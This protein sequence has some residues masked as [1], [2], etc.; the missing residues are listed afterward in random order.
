MDT[1]FSILK[2]D[3]LAILELEHA[4][5]KAH[6]YLPGE[7]DRMEALEESIPS[8]KDTSNVR[9]LIGE[10][11]GWHDSAYSAVKCRL[12]EL[13]CLLKERCDKAVL[14]DMCVFIDEFPWSRIWLLPKLV[15]VNT[16]PQAELHCRMKMDKHASFV[17]RW[18]VDQYSGC[19]F[20]KMGAHVNQWVTKH[21]QATME[22]G[23]VVKRHELYYEPL[24][25]F[26]DYLS[27]L[28]M[29]NFG[30]E[31]DVYALFDRVKS[32]VVESDEINLSTIRKIPWQHWVDK[33]LVEDE[34]FVLMENNYR[35]SYYLLRKWPEKELQS[36]I[37][38]RAG[39]I[40]LPEELF[41]LQDLIYYER[42][43]E[44]PNGEIII[45]ENPF[46][47]PVSLTLNLS[48]H[49]FLPHGLC[50]RWKNG[51]IVDAYRAIPYNR[52]LS[53]AENVRSIQESYV[54]GVSALSG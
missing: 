18:V 10:L 20:A 25:S 41:D 5:A 6:L 30:T 36:Y 15:L 38:R 19:A 2:K 33:I 13:M 47:N 28:E 34:R 37:E 35:K 26:S 40:S 27:Y 32:E 24:Y 54:F 8:V 43:K 53:I 17:G 51:T 48:D 3:V 44:F 9:G 21:V 42:F 45:G 46:G 11:M 16:D 1:D 52:G 23:T 39:G 7:Y 22:G 49:T 14:W 12:M 4:D 29:K 31:F 50:K